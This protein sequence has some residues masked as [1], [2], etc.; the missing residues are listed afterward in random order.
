MQNPEFGERLNKR[1]SF[2]RPLVN[3]LREMS[4]EWKVGLSTVV[5]FIG[6][7]TLGAWLQNPVVGITACVATVLGAHALFNWT[8]ALD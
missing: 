4:P 2:L 8:H 3:K 1:T 7:V 6:G 5:I